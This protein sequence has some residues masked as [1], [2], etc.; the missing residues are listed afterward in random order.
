[1]PSRLAALH[2]LANVDPELA[3]DVGP[4]AL[5]GDAVEVA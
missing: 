5:S 4:G 2:R 1:M 3:L